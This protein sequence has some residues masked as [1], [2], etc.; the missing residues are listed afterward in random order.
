MMRFLVFLIF[1]TS[2]AN[3]P[4]VLFSIDAPTRGNEILAAFSKLQ[5]TSPIEIA[6]QTTITT[7]TQG[8]SQG[9][10]HFVQ[11]ITSAP[12]STLFIVSYGQPYALRY[13]VVGVEQVIDL[14]SSTTPSP[15]PAS[16]NSPL[17]TASYPNNEIPLFSV[18]PVLRAN[19]ISNVISTLNSSPYKTSTSQVNIITT[20][21]GIQG[22]FNPPFSGNMIVNVSAAITITTSFCHTNSLL[23][24]FYSVGTLSGSA[25]VAAEQIQQIIYAY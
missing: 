13:M 10:I 25:I 12:N 11:S 18:D 14:V 2:F 23:Q 7:T 9:V 22:V 21:F 3:P 1:A 16:I 19:D 20:L 17:V 24:I 8:L 4:S 15:L 6:M 5:A